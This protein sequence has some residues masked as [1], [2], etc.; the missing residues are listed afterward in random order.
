MQL[1]AEHGP[2]IKT[3]VFCADDN[4]NVTAALQHCI[5]QSPDFAWMGCAEDADK[6]C[7]EIRRCG[8]PEIVLLDLD[9][10]GLD[11][12]RAIGLLEGCCECRVLVYSGMVR[13]ELIDR[14]LEAGAWGYVYKGDGGLALLEAM[15]TVLAGQLA[16]SPEARAVSG[17]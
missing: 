6:L 13:R 2:M 4:P 9:M 16:L 17:M 8:C 5:E 3:R 11:P 15:R 1:T 14:A 12:L 10:P 7:S